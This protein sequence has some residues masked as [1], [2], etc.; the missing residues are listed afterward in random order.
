MFRAAN[1]PIARA[2]REE[3]VSAE[4][5]S[6]DASVAAQPGEAGGFRVKS[7]SGVTGYLK[8]TK[9]CDAL[10]PRAANEKIV[11]D[12][13]WEVDVAVAPVVLFRR[14]PCPP[15]QEQRACVSLVVWPE[16]WI[17]EQLTQVTLSGPAEAL[18]RGAMARSCGVIALDT[19]VG[20]TD[21]SNP[22]NATIGIDNDNLAGAGFAYIDHSYSLN[23]GGQ[24][25]SQPKRAQVV[26]SAMPDMLRR[27]VDRNVLR[28]T[29]GRIEQVSDLAIEAIVGRIPADYMDDP[30][31][32]AVV[33]GLKERR[34]LVRP[35]LA[36]TF[37]L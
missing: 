33:T 18:V 22:R 1:H 20:N 32:A 26:L 30:H 15:D 35:V 13:A 9:Q 5:W 21:R 7:D 12:L 23:Y 29:V 14:D 3:V 27:A 10:N 34:P 24:W 17:L 11:A 6:Q 31:K 19:W 8:P 2:W 25:D 4:H 16:I 28:A 36:T 37:G